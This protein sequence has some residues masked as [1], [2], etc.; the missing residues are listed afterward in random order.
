MDYY[1]DSRSGDNSNTGAS[2]GRAW[3]DFSRINGTALGPGDNLLLRRGSHFRQQLQVEAVGTVDAW[4]RVTAYGEGPRPVVERGRKG[5]CAEINH[6]GSLDGSAPCIYISDAGYLEVTHI[7]VYNAP[8]GLLVNNYRES[9]SHVV[10]DDVVAMEIHNG[11]QETPRVNSAGIEVVVGRGHA[12]TGITLRHVTIRNCECYRTG[13]GI[14]TRAY[15]ERCALEHVTVERVTCHDNANTPWSYVGLFI[16][17]VRHGTYDGVCLD[18]CAPHWKPT[19]TA[20]VHYVR[21][22]HIV[23]RNGYIANTQ[24]TDSHD[25]GAWDFEAGGNDCLI[26]RCT[27]A[28][29]AGPAIEYLLLE[30][31]SPR[32]VEVRN[33]TF[34]NNDRTLWGGGTVLHIGRSGPPPTGSVHDNDYV[35]APGT[36]FGGERF[37]T[38]RNNRQHEDRGSLPPHVAPPAVDAGPDRTLSCRS[39]RL[40]G[41]V[42]NAT[43]WRWE[44]VVAPGEVAFDDERAL[45]TDVRFSIPGVYILRLVA[46]N[47]HLLYGDYVTIRCVDHAEADAVHVQPDAASGA[48]VEFGS[49][50][51]VTCRLRTGD[52]PP[53]KHA[54]LVAGTGEDPIDGFRLCIEW[55][56]GENGTVLLESGNGVDRDTAYSA[57]DAFTAGAWHELAVSLDCTSRDGRGEARIFLDG[58]DVTL[59]D[60]LQSDMARRVALRVGGAP[61]SVQPVASGDGLVSGADETVRGL[62]VCEDFRPAFEDDF[63]G[64]LRPEWRGLSGDW[65]VEGGRLVTEGKGEILCTRRFPGDVLLVYEAGTDAAQP[66]D[67]SAVLNAAPDNG[68]MHGYFFGFGTDNNARSKFLRRT[69]PI[70][71]HDARIV[72][73]RVHRVACV[74]QGREFIHIVDGTKRF[75]FDDPR[76]I[77]AGRQPY[78]ALY[79][80]AGGWFENVRVYTRSA[81]ENRMRPFVGELADVRYYNRTLR[82]GEIAALA[83]VC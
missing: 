45:E 46:E 33:C 35:L 4:I 24:D 14:S 21:S 44:A 73:G 78:V 67:L 25:M 1:F 74:R 18:R 79:V 43:G 62:P 31:D 32:D 76:P 63:S 52:L 37:F 75:S 19:G 69:G 60:G 61:G 6:T 7:T 57:Y 20:T 23:F 59:F 51:T 12:C 9:R 55:R 15:G 77:S 66:C 28:D 17:G 47:D 68:T 50:F 22:D 13:T 41:R 53:G 2:P 27:F 64:G 81:E 39:T 38:M 80:H 49:T 29:N 26:D 40:S 56:G 71:T 36:A 10:I 65:R 42:D 54:V 11:G 34:V 8:Y 83:G 3:R 5:E 48:A 82:P 70:G 16:R 30:K 58:Q 72:P